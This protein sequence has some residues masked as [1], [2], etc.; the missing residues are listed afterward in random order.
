VRFSLTVNNS[1]RGQRARRRW[2]L[3]VG[4]MSSDSDGEDLISWVFADVAAACG[5]GMARLLNL[6]AESIARWIRMTADQDSAVGTYVLPRGRE[7]TSPLP[8]S[9][10]HPNFISHA[11]LAAGQ[12]GAGGTSPGAGAVHVVWPTS[13]R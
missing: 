1:A 5:P 9:S 6:F 2:L 7:F 3:P 11:G 8:P 13:M 4:I 10:T 12:A